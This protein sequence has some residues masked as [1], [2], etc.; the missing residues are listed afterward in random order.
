MQHVASAV[1][2]PMPENQD[3]GR[4][5][6]HAHLGGDIRIVASA[7]TIASSGDRYLQCTHVH[8]EKEPLYGCS[9]PAKLSEGAPR[10]LRSLYVRLRHQ[11]I[12]PARAHLVIGAHVVR[13]SLRSLAFPP[14]VIARHLLI[15]LHLDEPMIIPAIYCDEV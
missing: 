2:S 10:S 13:P 12:A 3:H 14:H 4:R 1:P 5:K 9:M 11:E 15:H 7:W 6:V 8:L